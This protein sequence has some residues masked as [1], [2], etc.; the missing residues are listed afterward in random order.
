MTLIETL[1][2]LGTRGDVAIIKEAPGGVNKICKAAQV[3]PF[4]GCG[5]SVYI[6]DPGP[7]NKSVS[8]KGVFHQTGNGD[9]AFI[10]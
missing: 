10:I 4:L 9:I 3:E 8:S 2:H 5:S 1:S 7:C 6:R